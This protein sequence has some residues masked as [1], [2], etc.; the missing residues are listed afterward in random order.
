MRTVS[1]SETD[2]PIGIALREVDS[3]LGGVSGRGGL[4]TTDTGNYGSTDHMVGLTPS[5]PES[6]VG[7]SLYISP[8]YSSR[9]N[10]IPSLY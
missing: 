7:K 1:Q 10:N 6:H 4:R 3:I 9:D 2:G 5:Y 8:A